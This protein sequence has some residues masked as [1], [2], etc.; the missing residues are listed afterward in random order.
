MS[1]IDGGRQVDGCIASLDVLPEIAEAVGDKLDIS[2]SNP[3]TL[4]LRY[5]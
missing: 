5:R 3:L 1:T 2:E 4:P